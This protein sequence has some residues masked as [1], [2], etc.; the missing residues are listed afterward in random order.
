M[1]TPETIKNIIRQGE[2]LTVEFKTSFGEDTVVALDAFANTKGGVAVIG[3]SDKGEV[4]GTLLNKESIASWINEVKSK[5][6]KQSL[7]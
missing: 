1:L 7:R 6:A 5:T 4:V 2:G 3:V